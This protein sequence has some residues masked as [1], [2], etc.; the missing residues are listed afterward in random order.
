[1]APPRAIWTGNISFGLV[2]APVRMY[3]A[4]RENDL[5]FNMLH[6]EDGGRIGYVKVCKIDEKPVSDDEIV[7]AYDVGGGEFVEL[8]DED[9]AAAS[10]DGQHHQLTIHDFVPID[11][12]D[13]IYFERT[14]YLGPQEGPGEA[15]YA[16]L[17]QAMSSAGLAAMATYVHHNREHL[18]CLRVRD[19]VITLERMFFSD[20]VRSSDGLAPEAKVDERQ[21]KMAA[22]LIDAYTGDF[23]PTQYQDT[24]RD[25][26][27]AVI[28]QKR[29]GKTVRPPEVEK[30]EAPPDLMA[31]LAASLEEARKARAERT[32]KKSSGTKRPKAAAGAGGGKAP[33]RTR[34]R[35]S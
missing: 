35:A 11:Q 20:E 8:T 4:I 10:S 28:E 27:L 24:Y 18:G 31:A 2:N 17:A 25:K 23:D 15:I 30:D 6:Q 1:M 33:A 19:G 9:F 13:P 32:E 26:L 22:D 29:Q 14:Y 7:R 5:R 21:L 34:R 3:T 12:I 16:L